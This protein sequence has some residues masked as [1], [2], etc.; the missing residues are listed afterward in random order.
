MLRIKRRTE[1][2]SKPETLVAE[3]SESSD[4]QTQRGSSPP[5]LPSSGCGGAD[6]AG[7]AA[8]Y[9]RAVVAASLVKTAAG[10]ATVFTCTT[11]NQMHDNEEPAKE[12]HISA[13]IAVVVLMA[14]S[15]IAGRW[16]A[17]RRQKDEMVND[18]EPWVVVAETAANAQETPSHKENLAAHAAS[19]GDQEVAP[20]DREEKPLRGSER[21]S[22][23]AEP[24]S[25]KE[26]ASQA[27]CTYTSVRGH[28][29]GRFQPLPDYAHG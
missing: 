28:A 4:A 17:S 1:N 27:P 18:P 2:P 14:L 6:L 13:V 26:V 21:S 24:V 5:R 16:S 11:E 3:K 19:S 10:S 9:V 15:A 23:R 22:V 8:G 7:V 29:T 25:V 12:F 20:Q